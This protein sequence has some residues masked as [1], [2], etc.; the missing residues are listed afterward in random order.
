MSDSV[1]YNVDNYSIEDLLQLFL[2]SEE[3]MTVRAELTEHMDE[4][5]SQYEDDNKEN[6]CQF[7]FRWSE[8]FI[9][10]TYANEL[11]FARKGA[12]NRCK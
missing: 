5:I 3:P 10:E 4:K 11:N 9:R 8:C 1:D 6:V 12:T 2:R 7:F